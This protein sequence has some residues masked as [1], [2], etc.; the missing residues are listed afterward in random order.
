MTDPCPLPSLS[1][2]S[3]LFIIPCANQIRGVLGHDRILPLPSCTFPQLIIVK[4][5][6]RKSKSTFFSLDLLIFF[7]PYMAYRYINMKTSSS[8]ADE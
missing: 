3:W 2:G 4:F 6:M 1:Y 5:T 7:F 8:L